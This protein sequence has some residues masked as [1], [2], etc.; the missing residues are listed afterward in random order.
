VLSVVISWHGCA[1]LGRCGPTHRS[2]AH[3]GP[4]RGKSSWQRLDSVRSVFARGCRLRLP[5]RV[6]IVLRRPGLRTVAALGKQAV[7]PPGGPARVR[8]PR[9]PCRCAPRRRGAPS[10][11]E[12][13]RPA[14][15]EPPPSFLR[16]AFI[17]SDWLATGL[18]PEV[19]RQTL[20]PSGVRRGP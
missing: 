2:R 13:G 9:L 1:R 16:G 14:F 3:G 8:C 4:D 18:V 7:D 11:L 5:H 15:L 20:S 12:P 17:V 10:I 6:E 19:A